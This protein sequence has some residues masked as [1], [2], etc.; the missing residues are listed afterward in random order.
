M[1][2]QLIGSFAVILLAALTALQVAAQPPNDGAEFD[3]RVAPFSDDFPQQTIQTLYQSQ[4]GEL[5]IGTQEGLHVYRGKTVNSYFYDVT[6]PR[7]I[8]SDYITAVTQTTDGTILVGTRDGGLNTHNGTLPG[9]TRLALEGRP[10][11]Q[12]NVDEGVFSLYTDSNDQ[13]WVGHD[14]AISIVRR[15]GD[16][17]LLIDHSSTQSDVGLVNG[18]AETGN[19]IWAVTS[20]AGVLSIGNNGQILNRISPFKLFGEQGSS[21]QTTG[22]YAD[23]SGLLWIWSLNNGIAIVEPSSQEVVARLLSAKDVPPDRRRIYDVFEISEDHFWIGTGDGLYAYNSRHGTII[24]AAEDI[25]IYAS[26]NV[27]DIERTNDGTF[28]IGTIYGLVK[29]T[30]KTFNALSTLNTQLSDDS[31]NAFADTLSEGVWIGTQNGLNEYDQHGNVV[32]VLNELTQPSLSNP[33]VMSLYQEPY[34]LWV[35]TFAGGLNFLPAAG[36]ETR[37]YHHS[38]VDPTTIGS[39]GVTSIIRT[40]DGALLVGTYQGGLNMLDESGTKFTRFLNSPTNPRSISDNNVIAI[41]EDSQGVIYVGTEDG[42]NIFDIE[43]GSFTTIRS[44]RGKPDSLSSN[45][46]WCFFED[47]EGSLWIGTNKGG[48]NVWKL[49]DRKNGVAHFEHYSDL[50]KLPSNSIS[51]IS[52]DEEGY[53]WLSHNAGLTRLSKDFSYVRHF[54]KRDGLQDSEFNVGASFRTKEGRIL[55]G[56]NRG[57]NIIDSQNLPGLGEGPMVSVAEIRV[58]NQRIALPSTALSLAKFD[59]T[60]SHQDTLLE[61]DFFADSYMS[62]EDVTYAY[63]LDGLTRDWVI[64]KDKNRASFTTLPTGTYT[65][66][67]AA[68]SPT[69]EWSWDS[70]SL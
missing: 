58:M 21:V 25:A 37:V 53:I 50:V 13:V 6:D 31:I 39:M 45:L 9:F 27:I 54:G 30:E 11:E 7:T 14:G 56:G 46:V 64:G 32:R 49:E 18:F 60:L 70:A 35:G 28:W 59:V 44:T 29:A 48:I 12:P 68:A 36:G 20:A 16:F 33:S 42:L 8:S 19:S 38:R 3:F 55:F 34:G 52:E 10:D 2:R 23:S 65:L 1:A 43:E 69:G 66:R 17:E 47:S 41:F 5:W 24:S 40:R 67:M 62:P 51:G 4:T 63:T 22:I 15:N 26:P 61:V 57:F